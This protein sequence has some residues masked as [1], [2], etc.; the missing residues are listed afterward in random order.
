MVLTA[1]IE[2]R[3]HRI[4]LA[5]YREYDSHLSRGETLRCIGGEIV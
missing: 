2:I 4:S 1:A 3:K 5:S